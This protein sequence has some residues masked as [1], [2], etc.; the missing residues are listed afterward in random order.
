M[1]TFRL[2]MLVMTFVAAGIVCSAQTVRS[3]TTETRYLSG[4][5]KD[6]TVMWDF[7]CTEGRKSG[8]W[9]R[10]RVPSCWETEGFGSYQYGGDRQRET[11]PFPKE[12][13]KYRLTFEVPQPWKDRVV[14][15]VF[16]GSMT[17]TEVWVNGKSAGPMHQGS[18]YRFK[19]DITPLLKF[20]EPNLLEITVNKESSNVSV[21]RAERMTDYW[22]FGGIFRPVFLEALPP[23]FIDW[24]AIDARA[25]G[26]FA[27]DVNLAGATSAGRVSAQIIDLKGAPVGQPFTA[28]IS[29][30]QEAVKLQTNIRGP[31]LWTAETPNLY[32]VR[33]TLTPN[34]GSAHTVTERFGFRTF[35]VRAGDGFYLNGQRI[36]LKGVN[37]H[38]FWPE[39]GRTLNRQ[40]SH[41]DIKLIKDLNMNSVRMSHYPPDDH[42]L[43]ACDELGLYVLDELAGWQKFY[44]TPTGR[45]LIGQMVRRD[46]NH[47]SI[48][49]WDN[50]NEGGWNR[51]NDDEFARWDPQKR[52]VLHPW[53]KFRKTNTDHYEKFDSH[54]KLNNGPDIYMSTEFLH[55]LYDGGIGAG[56]WDYWELIRKSKVGGGGF[57]W[58]L[59]D[60]CVN[61]T[62]QNGKLDC[63]GN[64]GPDGIVGPHREKEGSFYT[65]KEIWSPVQ[66][67]AP[68][69]L[70]PDFR[71]HLPVEN[72]YDFTNLS[73]C[74]FE[75]QLARFSLPTEGK[76]GHTVIASGAMKGPNVAP[77]GIGE[78]Q[79]VLPRTWR[80]A[81]VLYL[82]AK[83]PSGHDL[84]TWSWGLNPST[85]FTRS[86]APARTRPLQTR[87]DAGAIVIRMGQTELS[88][89]KQTGALAEVR[90]NGKLLPF[91]LGPR[92]LAFRRNDRKY[93]DLAV[94]STLANFT[95]REEGK[96]VI[97]EATYN[98]P[99]RYARWRIAPDGPAGLKA[100]LDY[101]YVFD[102]LV[103][104]VGV[105]FKSPETTIDRVRWLGR[106]PYRVWQNRMQGTRLD[107]WENAYNDST[108][109][110]SWI[111]PEFK[112]YFRD[113][114]WAAFD[115]PG[116]RMTISTDTPDSF[117]G[118]FKPKDGVNG[119]L[120]LPD[121]GIALLDVIPAMRN[122]FHT[123]DEIGPQSKPRQ[124]S[125][126][127][128]RTLHFRFGE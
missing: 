127:V 31:R 111:Y 76:S 102:G 41:D 48:V 43:D 51:E 2:F 72:H 30:N 108:P 28:D 57:F 87:D 114:R 103:D 44:D 59:V 22:N 105:Q 60:E 25:D 110:E 19:Y 12:Q 33:L 89:S 123:T 34:S 4:T 121:I 77:H 117:L 1:K 97:V 71:G 50:G 14:R 47:P 122:K 93:D 118:L 23:K 81:D 86:G 55:G 125:G 37:R 40:I 98:G 120:D 38:S 99:L 8:V 68:E 35:E 63:A 9:T 115:T 18:F 107:V 95:S 69:K 101:E 26:S 94:E 53:E 104:M 85:S 80:N 16:D 106:G 92:F 78:M 75:W 56:M 109:G 20:G 21:N 49:L 67:V 100:Q 29:A 10:I 61:R 84:W 15:L 73:E 128:R 74:R 27:M 79:L 112:G 62:D 82:T 6:D 126:T 52:E 36:L 46:V 39:T 113:W 42:F 124:V 13:G 32:R 3:M 83:D 58:A 66:V 65:V 70:P 5:G 45:R 119:L 64:R 96:D 91:G 24:T 17:D 7:Y 11:N 54:I 90:R 88:F 116:G